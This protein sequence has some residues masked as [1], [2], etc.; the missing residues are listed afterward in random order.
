MRGPETQYDVLGISPDA[1]LKEI[2]HAY[3]K[4]ALKYHPDN[5]H[6]DPAKAEAKFRKL[7]KAY[8]RALRAHLPKCEQRN[9]NK[10]YSPADLAR[11]NTRWHSDRTRNHHAHASVCEQAMQSTKT[12]RSVATVDENRV[13]VLAWAI[14]TCLG[15]ALVLS[16]GS[17]G[18]FG[19][20]DDGMDLSHLLVVE[21]LAIFTV[22]AILAG[23]IYGLVLTRKTI[24]LTLQW[25][26]RL[27]P[28]L[29]NAR[30]SKQLPQSPSRGR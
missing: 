28:F 10:P 14:A 8:K 2:R 25:G 12:A 27:L 17:L 1:S 4:G 20:L 22:V 15:I 21:T 26:V 5:R 24:W 29:P 11:M 6:R 23:S 30:R 7:A 9:S 13:F 19:N 3:H 16:A 18:M